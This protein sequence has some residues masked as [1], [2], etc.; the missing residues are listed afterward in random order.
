MT[1]IVKSLFR[2]PCSHAQAWSNPLSDGQVAVV[3][4][5]PHL[6]LSLFYYAFAAGAENVMAGPTGRPLSSRDANREYNTVIVGGDIANVGLHQ[7]VGEIAAWII[8]SECNTTGLNRHIGCEV[9]H[10]TE[11]PVIPRM[12]SRGTRIENSTWLALA[13]THPNSIFNS[14][15]QHNP[16]M[17]SMKADAAMSRLV[18]AAGLKFNCR[19]N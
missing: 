8:W 17:S 5:Y 7:L 4:H 18:I 19:S 1:P 13:P 11:E 16:A 10:Y 15:R 6:I 12:K 2:S 9:R 14:S 3:R